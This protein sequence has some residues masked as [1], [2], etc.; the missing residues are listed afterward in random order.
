MIRR[1]V[2]VSLILMFVVAGIYAEGQQESVQ[3]GDISMI[4]WEG[5]VPMRERVSG[6][7][8]VLPEGWREATAGVNYITFTNSGS[9][10]YDPAMDKNRKAFEE[11]TGIEVRP[12]VV[13]ESILH[14]KQAAILRAKSP[15]LDLLFMTTD[16]ENYLD[17]VKAGWLEACDVLYNEAIIQDYPD[18]VIDY[19]E[20]DGHFWGFTYI[21]SGDVLHYR[22]DSLR[23]A[24]YSQPPET[25]AELVEVAQKL[26]R[27]TNGDGE[28]D[29]YGMAYNVGERYAT[30]RA[31]Q[32]WA[33]TTGHDFVQNGRI[34]YYGPKTVRTLQFMADLRNRYEVAPPGVVTY[35]MTDVGKLMAAGSLGMGA[36]ML[37]NW[38]HVKN[39]PQVWKQYGNTY[40]PKVNRSDPRR[41]S[42]GPSQ[43]GV[44]TFSEK[45]AA[46]MLY[47]DYLRSMEA[48]RN[49]WI[50][51]RNG[52]PNRNI[53]SMPGVMDVPFAAFVK[54]MNEY[55]EIPLFP[56]KAEIIEMLHPVVTDVVLGEKTADEGLK[57]LQETIDLLQE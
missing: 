42:A 40:L 38:Q 51:E 7:R 13:P 36:S 55:I 47:L 19:L 3:K 25:W 54:E 43:Y 4:N 28:P 46:A 44:S 56:N 8:Y 16:T 57:S 24:G 37:M 2:L 30:N 15:R 11:L 41:V 17:Y 20:Q 49:E 21:I 27:D 35:G 48:A 34:V 10:E 50:M 31:F 23:R 39:S 53:W 12:M 1:C 6:P 26:T 18:A 5:P 45:K 14:T 22:K 32:S 29:V 52:R 33:V 9:L